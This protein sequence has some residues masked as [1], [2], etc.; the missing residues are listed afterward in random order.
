MTTLY[1]NPYDISFTG[2]YFE[3]LDEFQEKMEKAPFEEVEIDYIDGD[4]PSLFTQAGINQGNIESWFDELEH[5]TD[6]DDE[7]IAIRY[8]LDVGLDLQDAIDRHDE[9][10]IHRGTAEDYAQDLI[11]ETTDMDSIPQV[12]QYHID[13]QGIANDMRI[14]GEITEIQYGIWVTNCLDF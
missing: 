9:V 8:L 10:Q 6:S 14:N 11:E 5:I 2:F 4:A 1:A 12:I 7:A 13:Y 3:N